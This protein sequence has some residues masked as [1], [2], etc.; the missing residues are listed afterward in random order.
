M[1]KS[2]LIKL[3]KQEVANRFERPPETISDDAHFIKDL[4]ADSLDMTEILVAVEDKL[5]VRIDDDR[6]ERLA[7]AAEVA[8]FLES[9]LSSIGY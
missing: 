9:Y 8:E 7:T 2:E 5:G 4:G 3:I 6:I 1:T